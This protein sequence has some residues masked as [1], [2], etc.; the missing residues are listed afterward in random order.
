MEKYPNSTPMELPNGLSP[1]SLHNAV[2][3]FTRF[4]GSG[5]VSLLQPFFRFIIAHK[6]SL[7]NLEQCRRL[8]LP[9]WPWQGYMLPLTPTLHDELAYRQSLQ[10]W[11]YSVWFG[12]SSEL[13][14]YLSNRLPNYRMKG[15]C[16]RY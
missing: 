13:F 2:E 9:P 4:K 6:K 3:A 12:T 10:D 15:E 5:L 7:K 1:P 14:T 11:R 16:R 8:E